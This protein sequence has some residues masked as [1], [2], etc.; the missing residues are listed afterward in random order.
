MHNI[1]D[2]IHCARLAIF[3]SGSKIVGQKQEWLTLL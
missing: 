1:G 2:D 3:E